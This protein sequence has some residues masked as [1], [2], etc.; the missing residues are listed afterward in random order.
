MSKVAD[1][2]SSF[3][4]AHLDCIDLLGD[5]DLNKSLHLSVRSVA[6]FGYPIM[7]TGCVH[8]CVASFWKVQSASSRVADGTI[9]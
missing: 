2:F 1:F 9:M 5:W 7:E 4:S 3:S 8:W 6:D